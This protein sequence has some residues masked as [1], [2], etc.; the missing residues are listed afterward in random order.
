LLELKS[1]SMRRSLDIDDSGATEKGIRRLRDAMPDL[2]IES[3]R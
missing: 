2:G 1:L 3:H